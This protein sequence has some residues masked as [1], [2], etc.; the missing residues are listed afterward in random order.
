MTALV[1]ICTTQKSENCVLPYLTPLH[2]LKLALHLKEYI[3]PL[4]S[5]T[6]IFEW[7]GFFTLTLPRACK[8]LT[9]PTSDW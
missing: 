1:I 8:L 6:P 2:V 7:I 9:A 5:N 3:G 4:L